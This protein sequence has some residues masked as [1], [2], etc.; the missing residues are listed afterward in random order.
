MSA[1]L[2]KESAACIVRV[3]EV[4]DIEDGSS[5]VSH[6]RRIMQRLVAWWKF[7]DV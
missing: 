7:A 4:G 6:P 5:T 3:E 2:L 1:G